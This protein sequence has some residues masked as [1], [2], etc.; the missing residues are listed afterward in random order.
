M[1]R[2][3]S[4]DHEAALAVAAKAPAGKPV[5]MINILRFHDQADYGGRTDI[6]PCT[7]WEAILN[8]TPLSR[9]RW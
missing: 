7:E 8:V 2:T 5:V 3:V 9:R 4:I 1:I 6:T